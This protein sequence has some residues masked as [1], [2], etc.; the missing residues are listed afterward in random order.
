MVEN[1]ELVYNDGVI[2]LYL[3]TKG[4]IG[5]TEE[6]KSLLTYFEETTLENAVD[7]ELE[8]IQKIVGNIKHSSETED[9]YMTLQEII[10]HE[11]DSSYSDGVR[12]GVQQGMQQGLQ[13]GLEQGMQ[14][15]L[16]Q[17]M[18]QGIIR[19]CQNL[20][21]TKEKTIETLAREC[22]ITQEEAEEYIRLYW[23]E[24]NETN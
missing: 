8:E 1:N 3:Y 14:Q 24:E 4:K 5:G 10:D 16:E 23:Q 19:T 18:Q 17:G 21:Q 2:K 15:G 13:Q 12:A 7:A 9:R 6:L 20:N 22:N 11:K